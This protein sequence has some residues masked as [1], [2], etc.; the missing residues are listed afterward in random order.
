MLNSLKSSGD[1]S[2]AGEDGT[3]SA[4]RVSDLHL[5]RDGSND[6]RDLLRDGPECK[7][8]CTD[9]EDP[10]ND[11]DEYSND[12]PDERGGGAVIH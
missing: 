9:D 12:E 8:D 5:L 3:T 1:N 10:D 4:G 2:E 7:D 6:G 11:G